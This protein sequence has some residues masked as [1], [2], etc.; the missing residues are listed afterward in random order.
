[1]CETLRIFQTE[2]AQK[3]KMKANGSTQPATSQQRLLK[4]GCFTGY[5]Q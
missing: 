5:Q 3:A 1:M 2:Q 4:C